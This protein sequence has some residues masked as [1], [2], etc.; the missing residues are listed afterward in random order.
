[1]KSCMKKKHGFTLIEIV[2]V[3]AIIGLLSS[4]VASIFIYN[5]RFYNRESGKISAISETRSIAD[6]I[7]EYGRGASAFLPTYTYNSVVYTA[8]SA[9]AV[10]RLPAMNASGDLVPGVS[11][12]VVVG[13][14][15][16]NAT[17]LLLILDAGTGSVRKD[18]ILEVSKKLTLVNFSY[19]HADFAQTKNMTFQ[20]Q[21]TYPG[22][23][24][25]VETVTGG[26]TLRN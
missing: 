25:A 9:L 3:I 2:V 8:G 20:V 4:F 19:D 1:M 15:P 24:P 21:I 22:K 10:L 23:Y 18:R 7:E 6:K 12:H 16:S 5:N 17:R 11:D 13:R 14:D 26:V